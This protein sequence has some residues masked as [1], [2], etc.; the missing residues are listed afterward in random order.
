MIIPEDEYLAHYGTPRHS[1]RYP[2][3][4][5]E[6]GETSNDPRNMS[7]L[8]HV[9]SMKK[10][11]LTET[12]IAEGV[13]MTT[14]QL[15]AQKSIEKNRLKQQQIDT[16]QKYKDKGMSNVAIGERMGLNESS[17]RQ[18]LAPG[19]KDKLDILHT[20]AQRLKEQVEN[21]QYLDIGTGTENHVG[22]PRDK[23]NQ[24]IVLLQNDGY[25][26]HYLK[27]PQLG[28]GKDTNMKVL[29]KPGV[30]YS[31]V[32]KNRADVKQFTDFSDD[33]GRTFKSVQPP[34]QISAKR[35]GV[36]YAEQ[37]GTEADG[38]IY[39]R[40]GVSDVSLGKARY[41]Q[42]RVAVEGGRY[43]KGMAVYKDDLPEGVDLVFN[44]NKSDTG[45]KL[46]AMK[47]ISDDPESPFGAVVRQ[48]HGSD[49]KPSSTMN[50][51]NEEGDWDDWSRNLS[52]QLLSKQTPK[53]AERQLSLS[54]QT[55]KDGLAEIMSLSNPTV[56][57]RLL[58]SFADDADAA[59]VHLKAA[60]INRQRTQ[61]IL[62]I[63]SLSD[64]E[65]YAPNFRNGESV[66]LVRYPHGGIFEIP[67]LTVNNNHP[68]AKKILGQAKDAVGINAKVAERLSGAD[69]DGDTVL[70]IPNNDRVIKTAPPLDKLKG[71]DPKASYPA[72]EGMAK[73]TPRQKGFEMGDVSNLITDMTIKGA[74][75]DE[76]ARAVRHS[77][78]VIDA[79]KHNLNWKQSAIDNNIR[80]LKMKYQRR[81]DGRAGGAATLISRATS[82]KVVNDRVARRASAG[83]AIDRAT[84]KKV[85]EE[86][87]ASYIGKKG[88]VV[89]KKARSTKLA[90]AE[91][92]HELSSGTNIEKVYAD[93]SNNLKALANEARK[94]LLATPNLKYSPSAKVAY[95]AEV[96]S[97]NKK[98]QVAVSNRPLERQAQVIANGIFSQKKAANPFMEADEI[99]R[100]KGKAL[101]E[102]RLRTGAKKIKID[103]TDQEWNAIQAGA[104]T[105]SKLNDILRNSDLDQ[106][107]KLATPKATLE[108]TSTKKARAQL[109]MNAGYTQAEVADALGVSVSTLKTSLKEG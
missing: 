2:W 73:M 21:K 44:T 24:A 45:N 47:K 22:V 8:D 32:Y 72:Y 78:V 93:Y 108:M 13:G 5:G 87:G 25:K 68:E 34:L 9:E 61:V 69:F 67:E 26:V 7:F 83:G 57:Q 38:V 96:E 86:T 58:E 88:E 51:V 31:E 10:R 3:G 80:D 77:M 39:V 91:D 79:E 75:K 17:V 103:I 81:D 11:G 53:L 37:G 28:T 27:V 95:K 63:N 55:R 42:V 60:A 54:Y 30:P 36:R 109:M 105:N 15:R 1:G 20:T 46:D 70:V 35:V 62:P 102:A 40:P 48:I 33:G 59:A 71:F 6:D 101:T 14:T 64:K 66:V 16:A 76:L 89:L 74:N 94:S 43:L 98:L 84:G 19:E 12:Q 56:K 106:V 65:I 23:L 92:A 100:E 18:L 99:K 41:A 85:Y 52:T 104:I 97:L 49:G 29:S 50:I 90:E 107:K 82:P 4:S